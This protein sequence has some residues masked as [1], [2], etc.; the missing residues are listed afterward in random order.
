[1]A[2]P[3]LAALL[4]VIQGAASSSGGGGG[5]GGGDKL[6]GL[7]KKAEAPIAATLGAVQAGVETTYNNP[8]QK[9]NRER[10]ARLLALQEGGQL[11]L[12][13]AK[14]AALSQQLLS[15]VQAAALAARQR[16]EQVAGALGYQSGADLARLRQEQGRETSQA[17]LTAAAAIAAADDAERERQK[18]EIEQR[19]AL[20]GGLRADDWNAVF[21]GAAGLAGPIGQSLGQSDPF[22]KAPAKP[23]P[24]AP[25]TDAGSMFTAE[26]LE[27]LR[28]NP[29]LTR[30]VLAELQSRAAAQAS[31]SPPAAG[32]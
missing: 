26:E 1:M 5:G 16:S 29:E 13:G 11:G 3:A 18:Q 24:V 23:A 17:A 2:A 31:A 30:S 20:K 6:G 4:P 22:G 8:L 7:A 32:G 10:L 14:Q 25:T 27:L 28:A 21:R 9:L 19:T 15:P 12:T